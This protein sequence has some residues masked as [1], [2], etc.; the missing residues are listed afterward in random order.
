ME[1]IAKKKYSDILSEII[2]IRKIL[3]M[4]T[5]ETEAIQEAV[6][7][8]PLL[9]PV[10]GEF[11]AGKSTLLNALIG[12]DIL[13][14]SVKPETAIPAELYYSETEFDIGIKS[15]GKE[16]KITDINN[17]ASNYSYV[18]RYINSPYLKEI[19]PIVLVDM[20]GFDSP[21]DAH[22][23]AIVSYLERGI[24]YAMLIPSDAG[25]I[26]KS[27]R[28]Q[29]QN[30]IAFNKDCTFFI[31][32]SDL[33]S[34]EEIEQVKEEISSELSVLT[35]QDLKLECVNC[36][37][38]SLFS[39]FVDNMDPELLFKKQFYGTVLDECLSVKESINTR[40]AS[41]KADKN[42]NAQA[43]NELNASIDK[44]EAKKIE[45]IAKA[46]KSSFFNE[47][48]DVADA[49]GKDINA[50]IDALVEDAK[51]GREN[52]ERRINSIMQSSVMSA[53]QSSIE[54]VSLKYNEEFAEEFK[55]LETF[56]TETFGNSQEIMGR[57]QTW[58]E[59]TNDYIKNS[60]K[61]YI[62][63]REKKWLPTSDTYKTI[64]A[65]LAAGTNIVAPIVEIVIILLPDIIN[66][67]YS[68]IMQKNQ[69]EKI[70][71]M[72]IN[73]IPEIKRKIREHTAKLL[74]ENS[75]KQIEAISAQYDEKLKKK[76]EEINKASEELEKNSDEISTHI[77]QCVQYLGKIDNLMISIKE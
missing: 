51:I 57:I 15:D 16:E 22:N 14:V 50:E 40:L 28:R 59:K 24:H 68:W 34:N 63:K 18:R 75:E 45:M 32:K 31:S 49:V 3:K 11:S 67:V 61:D 77:N 9:I 30:I 41:L 42:K 8:M 10:V 53:V 64:T 5:D 13:K 48:S 52:F 20:P 17:A 56:L 35:G 12:K 60:V 27:M 73:Q 26:T 65:I 25:T 72:I 2:S 33:R 7:D 37:D 71:S 58:A 39:Q 55:D 29:V 36:K 66:A 62:N 23:K 76:R 47:A 54:K 1:L 4:S 6:A 44:L 69:D 38:I 19:Q 21:L 74:K 46:R 70:R 43:I